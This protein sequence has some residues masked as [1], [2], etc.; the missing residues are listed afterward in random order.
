MSRESAAICIAPRGPAAEY[1][2]ANRARAGPDLVDDCIAITR[3][4]MNS[5]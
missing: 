2:H 5:N 1:I 3:S 4:L